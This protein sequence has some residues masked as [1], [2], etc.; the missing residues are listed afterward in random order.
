MRPARGDIV[1]RSDTGG[2]GVVISGELVH[3][4]CNAV[5]LCTVV[6]TADPVGDFPKAVLVGEQDADL[7]AVP[8]SVNTAPIAVVAEVAGRA[9]AEQLGAVVRAHHMAISP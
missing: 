7:W 4:S 5:I 1:R 6:R 2:L 8:A 9:E 3:E